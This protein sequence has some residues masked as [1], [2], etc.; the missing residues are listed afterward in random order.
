MKQ[1][2]LFL[3]EDLIKEFGFDNVDFNDYFKIKSFSKFLEII[4][5]FD[6]YKNTHSKDEYIKMKEQL[7]D[8]FIPA[9]LKLG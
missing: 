8:E 5:N 6:E 9:E 1:T 4:K 7:K 2:K 3:G